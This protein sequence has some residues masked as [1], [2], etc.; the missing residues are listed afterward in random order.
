MYTADR[1]V[2]RFASQDCSDDVTSEAR[3]LGV[4]LMSACD[5]AACDA[6]LLSAAALTHVALK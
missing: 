1:E 3:G 6:A 5:G 4:H 2:F